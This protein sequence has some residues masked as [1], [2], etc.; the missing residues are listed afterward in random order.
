[1]H[2]TC[3]SCD[4]IFLYFYGFYLQNKTIM[5][6]NILTLLLAFSLTISF[7]QIPE[8]FDLRDY[9]GQNYVTSVK[10]QTGGTCWTHGAMAAMEGN[11]L[12]TGAWA[13]AGETGEPNLAEYHLD[14]WNGFNQ[15]YNA[16]TDPPTGGGLEVHQGGDYRVTTAYLSRLDGAVR[17]V[18]GQSYT[19]PPEFTQEDFHY[20][21]PIDVIWLTAGENLENMDLIKQM[22]MDYGV[23]GT[24]MC[25]NSA[26]MNGEYE[27]YQPP[28]NNMDPNHAVAIIGWDDNRVTQA[29]EPGAWL[30]K[31]SWGSGWGVGGYFWISYY[32]KHACQHPEMGAVSFQNVD[33][34]EV[35]G[36]DFAYYHDYH[37]WRDVLPGVTE[38]F[39]AFEAA[40]GN[41]NIEA[42][43]FFTAVHNVDYTVKI[44]GAFDGSSLSNELASKSGNIAYSGLHAINLDN[45]VPLNLGQHF[46][47]YLS[48]SQGGQ[49]YDRTS[50]VPV[51]LGAK[52]ATLVESAASPGESYYLAPTKGWT[53]FYDYDDPSGYLNT[54][55][56]CVK[57]LMAMG[58][59][60]IN[61]N[62]MPG[63]FGLQQNSPNPF[64][65]T[66]TI[67][68]SLKATANVRLD[69][70]DMSGRL[71]ANLVNNN[72]AAG[73]YHVGWDASGQEA[74]I[75][76][77][78]INV[79]GKTATR[80]MV[81]KR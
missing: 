29:P 27:H 21:Y 23:L 12:M 26:F 58:P 65:N 37:G 46:Y 47:V 43:S 79:N 32:D 8:T 40:Y 20:Y 36:F 24:C 71:V 77:C 1:M 33:N 45:E 66:T 6:K 60:G 15:Y 19:T 78:R 67:H 56:F 11:L 9:N 35:L 57:A 25:Y 64:N 31:N 62:E 53:D 18:D 14:W 44:Y 72:M 61:Q 48:L 50:V 2:K 42:V 76:L 7:A 39:N 81:L 52:S 68:Y 3:R 73:E 59:E 55:N 74:G 28:S 51:L 49:P 63:E 10:S 16:D 70:L 69:I 17:D 80:K 5:K 30:V 38:V 41:E 13:A 22:V 75:Y 54:G 34:L 4:A